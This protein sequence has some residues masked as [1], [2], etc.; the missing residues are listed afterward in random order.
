MESIKQL[1]S[2]CQC[3][4]LDRE[5]GN[6]YALL[7]PLRVSIYITRFLLPFGISANQASVICILL[8]YLGCIFFAFGD[9]W[10]NLAGVIFLHLHFIFDCIDGEIARYRGTSSLTGVY[11]D[12]VIHLITQPFIYLGIGV[13]LY[14][15][16]DSIV[17]IVISALTAVSFLVF[18]HIEL[19]RYHVM[20]KSMLANRDRLRPMQK[21]SAGDNSASG[22]TGRRSL[23]IE[24]LRQLRY[25]NK[26]PGLICTLTL[27]IV[28][29]LLIGDIVTPLGR[30]NTIYP[31]LIL[32]GCSM[33]GLWI[34]GL[35]E[36]IKSRSIDKEMEKYLV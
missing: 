32:F 9:P 30:T 31:A 26:S 3:L 5:K 13:G 1:R 8:G 34:L 22:Q 16:F 25:W 33:T 11:F 36:A 15:Q 28:I 23:I 17:P 20:Y 29:D 18:E 27:C 6:Y 10:Y 2:R 14:R 24:I 12:T 4:D 7:F 19:S 21:K 35:R